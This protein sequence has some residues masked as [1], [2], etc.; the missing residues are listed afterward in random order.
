MQPAFLLCVAA[1]LLTAAPAWSEQRLALVIGNANYAD[2]STPLATTIADVQAIAGE[3]HRKGFEV[4]LK[5]NLGTGRAAD[6][7]DNRPASNTWRVEPNRFRQL[8][9]TID[10]G[11]TIANGRF[12]LGGVEVPW[13]YKCGS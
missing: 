2:A 13:T 12:T 6:G 9:S 7:R 5:E 3:L 1:A 8:D 4:D 11:K 10:G